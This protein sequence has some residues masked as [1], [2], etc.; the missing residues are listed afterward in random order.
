MAQFPTIDFSESWS[1]PFEEDE[2]EIYP[3]VEGN[4]EQEELNEPPPTD[5]PWI[6]SESSHGNTEAENVIYAPFM[7]DYPETSEKGIAYVIN[8]QGIPEEERSRQKDLV[9]YSSALKWS[10]HTS[11][12][13]IVDNARCYRMSA[14]CTGV[15]ACQYLAQEIVDLKHTS[16]EAGDC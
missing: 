3:V 11:T 9:Q 5:E 13:K 1:T 8:L 4:V 15:K 6:I 10:K 2:S 12:V 16:F 7:P 14:I